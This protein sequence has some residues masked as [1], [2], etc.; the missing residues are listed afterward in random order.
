MNKKRSSWVKVA[1]LNIKTTTDGR[2][3]F[4]G[5][6]E[7]KNV[8]IRIVKNKSDKDSFEYL[9][10]TRKGIANQQKEKEA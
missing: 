7:Q 10:Y 2:K 4:A 8:D 5:R 9:L 1:G 6:I 3:Y